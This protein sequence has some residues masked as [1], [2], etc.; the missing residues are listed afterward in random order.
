MAQLKKTIPFKTL[1]QITP[2]EHQAFGNGTIAPLSN[3]LCGMQYSVSFPGGKVTY[4]FDGSFGRL[5]AFAGSDAIII[6]DSNIA[7]LYG[8][9]LAGFKTVV[10]PAGEEQKSWQ[11]VERIAAQL[12]EHEAHRKT[13]LVG[14]GGGVITDITGFIA[15]VYMRGV[16]FGFVPTTLLGMVDASVG[17]KNGVNLGRQKN[18]LGAIRQPHFILYDTDL[19]K[20]LPAREWS[21]GFAEV[22]KYACLFDADMFEELARQNI[23]FYTENP[24]AL[25]AIIQKCT[26][27][28]NKVVLED[29]Q[30]TGI[31]KLLNLGHTAGHAFETLYKLPHGFAVGLGL[32][33]ACIISEET[34]GLDKEVKAR[35]AAMLSRYGL[36]TNL[37]FDVPEAMQV[38]KMDKKRNGAEM[39]YIVLSAIG[40]PEIKKVSFET[41]HNALTRFAHGGHH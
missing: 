12:L 37:L 13:I 23:A 26:T 3:Y 31:R 34:N 19:L 32:I 1:H 16:R 7:A 35:I 36:P 25:S 22:I 29:E 5:Q 33:V 21:N 4:D 14:L 28:K 27:L 39:D 11:M 8:A 10:I 41:I 38:L 24:D 15:S 6:T 2:K 17:G 9:Y 18:F 30:E 20:T 40:N